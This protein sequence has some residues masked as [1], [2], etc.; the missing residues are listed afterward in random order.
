MKHTNKEAGIHGFQQSGFHFKQQHVLGLTWLRGALLSKHRGSSVQ[1]HESVQSSLK[2]ETFLCAL[3]CKFHNF[4]SEGRVR[5]GGDAVLF[6][7]KPG[8]LAGP[9]CGTSS[10]GSCP[11]LKTMA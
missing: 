10:H 5:R 2:S 3:V 7:P 11:N 9:L 4:Q 8:S 6:S 1:A